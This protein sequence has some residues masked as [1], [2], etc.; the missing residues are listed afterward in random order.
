MLLTKN[1]C[2]IHSTDEDEDE[3]S[4]ERE[5]TWKIQI[6]EKMS[7]L[8]KESGPVIVWLDW[9]VLRRAFSTATNPEN[10]ILTNIDDLDIENLIRENSDQNDP[11]SFQVSFYFKLFSDIEPCRE[12]LIENAGKNESSSSHLVH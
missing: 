9:K 2:F 11:T 5:E 7:Q 3:D 4:R 10:K 8:Q 1:P 6:F 12:F